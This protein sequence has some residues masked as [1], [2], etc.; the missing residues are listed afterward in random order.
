VCVIV[1]DF[2]KNVDE[3]NFKGCEKLKKVVFLGDTLLEGNDCKEFQNIKKLECN[4]F[5][6]Q[7]A[8]KNVRN[9]IRSV[10]LLEG[11]LLLDYECMKDFKNLEYIVIPPS[12]QFIGGKCFSG[13]E[14]LEKIYLPKTIEMISEDAFENC[15]KLNHF[16]GN[17]K[18]LNCLPKEQITYLDI[19]NQNNSIN[20][21]G[22]SEFKNLKKIEFNENMENIPKNNFR[23]CPKLTDIICSKNLF[24]NLKNEDKN[25]FQNVELTDLVGEIPENLFKNCPNL[26]NINIPYEANLAKKNLEKKQEPTTVEE[27]M[28]QDRDNLK[29]KKYLIEILT[30][31]QSQNPKNEINGEKNS[32]EE[33]QALIR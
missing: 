25:N 2:V 5:V 15:P 20:D 27:I 13:C 32:V 22:F 9:N 14:K 4:P 23:D 19:L 26:E 33:I 21:V 11:S 30:C 12:L 7:N 3:N 1:P 10:T 18:F 28:Q 6:L 8:K 24:Q 31:V 29:Y 16:I 17:S